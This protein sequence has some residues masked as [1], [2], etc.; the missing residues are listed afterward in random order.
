MRVTCDSDENDHSQQ[1]ETDYTL[2][3]GDFLPYCS[4]PGF[5]TEVTPSSLYE[6]MAFWL[7]DP[8]YAAIFIHNSSNLQVKK[9]KEFHKVEAIPALLKTTDCEINE[10]DQPANYNAFDQKKSIRLKAIWDSG[11]LSFAPNPMLGIPYCHT[12]R[13]DFDLSVAVINQMMVS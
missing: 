12:T 8:E 1:K 7:L 5:Q 11:D 4:E 10:A 13:K 6:K 3:L 9:F 2:F